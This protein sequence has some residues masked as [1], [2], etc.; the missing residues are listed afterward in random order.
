M[1]T[2]DRR[3]PHSRDRFRRARSAVVSALPALLLVTAC[4]TAVPGTA[5]PQGSAVS[6]LAATAPVVP[7]TRPLAELLL[8]AEDFPEPY[9]AIVLPPQAVAQAAPDLTGIPVGAK[10]SPAG[11]LP[12]VQDYGPDG[13]AMVVGTDND[14]RATISVE[15]V[16]GAAAL[17]DLRAYLTDCAHVESSYRGAT[18]T[19]TTVPEPAPP[20]PVPGVGTLE[21]SRTVRSGRGTDAITQSMRTRIAQ[22]GDLRLL[23]T[24]MSF[25]DGEPDLDNLGL[26]YDS[27]L[28]RILAG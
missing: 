13:T 6:G 28:A 15:L 24:Y 10:V 18:A 4:A 14:R 23:V 12:P 27:A 3:E 21:L 7:P 25:G 26:V 8:P 9:A 1:A 22:I 17:D 5:V 16:A 11:C 20:S 19:V 2:Y